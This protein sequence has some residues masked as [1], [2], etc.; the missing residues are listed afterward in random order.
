MLVILLLVSSFSTG[1][2]NTLTSM[3]SIVVGA[4]R[5]FRGYRGEKLDIRCSYESGYEAN[6]KYFCKGKGIFGRKDI[7]IK[8]G[9][10]AK[11]DKFSLTDDKK[12]RVFTITITDLR[13]EDAGRYWCAVERSLPLTDVYSE[14]SLKV[15]QN[16]E[17]TEGSSVSSFSNTPSYFSSTQ[18]NLQ[19]SS[20]TDQHNSTA[21][22]TDLG[23]VAGGLG[24]VLLV[25]L[26]CSGTFLILKKRKR[27][28]ETAL[29]LQNVQQNTETDCV[30][31]EILDSDVIITAESSSNQTPASDLNT[32]PEN[33]V[34]STVTNQQPDLHSSHTHSANQVTDTDCDYYGNITSSEIYVTATHPQNNTKDDANIYS[35]IKHK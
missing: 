1:Q 21:S 29:P 8:S 13:T 33:V 3:F 34:Y 35:L 11:H 24:S 18:V 26:L 28:C 16:Q 25:L 17:N 2:F 32:R 23:S 10:P 14:I 6:S 27:K 22:H 20:S 19:S 5:T 12:S 9:S 30:Y 15:E 31:E 4:P 7:I